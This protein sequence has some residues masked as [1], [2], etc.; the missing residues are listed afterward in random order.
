M[1]PTLR[2]NRASGAHSGPG[3][4][5]FPMSC[6]CTPTL[7]LPKSSPGSCPALPSSRHSNIKWGTHAFVLVPAPAL[8]LRERQEQKEN[9]A[10]A[11]IRSVADGSGSSL[12]SGPSMQMS[13][14]ITGLCRGCPLCPCSPPTPLCRA[15]PAGFDRRAPA[16]SVRSHKVGEFASKGRGGFWKGPLCQ[17]GCGLD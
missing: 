3:W 9:G 5:G 13:Q 11:Q 10:S 17:A 14:P 4:A 15:N 7:A 16:P 6:S 1:A 12:L 2:G 8:T